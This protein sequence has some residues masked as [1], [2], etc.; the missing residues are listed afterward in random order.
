MEVF[1]ETL[2]ITG[3]SMATIFAVMAGLWGV[4]KIL[5]ARDRRAQR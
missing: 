4:V 3:I 1:S 2:R 5:T